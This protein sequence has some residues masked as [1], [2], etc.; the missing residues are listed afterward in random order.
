MLP[1]TCFLYNLMTGVMPM[2]AMHPSHLPLLKA[3]PRQVV[4]AMTSVVLNSCLQ[5]GRTCLLWMGLA[6]A[7][8]SSSSDSSFISTWAQASNS[9]SGSEF[10]LE[11]NRISRHMEGGS[12]RTNVHAIMHLGF[13]SNSAT[14]FLKS[15]S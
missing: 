11:V 7:T 5:L 9:S 10:I 6:A 8:T 1:L 4:W 12:P 2:V 13:P 3:V 15:A 14:N